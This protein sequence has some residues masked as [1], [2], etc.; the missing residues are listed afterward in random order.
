MQ[1][2]LIVVDTRRPSFDAC[3]ANLIQ[4][5]AVELWPGAWVLNTDLKGQPLRT[6]IAPLFDTQGYI[7]TPFTAAPTTSAGITAGGP[8]NS[9]A[10]FVELIA[11]P[12]MAQGPQMPGFDGPARRELLRNLPEG[13]SFGAN[14]PD[15]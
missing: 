12:I 2:Y 15:Q 1:T 5:G 4:L 9:Q 3:A 6:A 13:Q 10:A 14:T 8:H 7:L 11:G